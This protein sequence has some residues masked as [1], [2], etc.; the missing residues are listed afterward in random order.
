[1]SAA[2]EGT[3]A[4]NQ[5][6]PTSSEHP[7]QP[8]PLG[9]APHSLL[10]SLL[11]GGSLRDGDDSEGE[12]GGADEEDEEEDGSSSSDGDDEHTPLVRGLSDSK[13]RD[14][15]RE[16]GAN[17]SRPHRMS[18]L[19]MLSVATSDG[20]EGSGIY[21]ITTGP[22]VVMSTPIGASEGVHDATGRGGEAPSDSI[23]NHT[24]ETGGSVDKHESRWAE[25]FALVAGASPG[26][27][28]PQPSRSEALLHGSGS[29][30]QC[31]SDFRG[32]AIRAGAPRVVV[33][34]DPEKERARRHDALLAMQHDSDES[35]GSPAMAC[36]DDDPTPRSEQLDASP[37]L[38][39]T[40]SASAIVRGRSQ[41]HG[42]RGELQFDD[43]RIVEDYNDDDDYASPRGSPGRGSSSGKL[44][45][46]TAGALRSE[47]RQNE[48]PSTDLGPPRHL[49]RSGQRSRSWG[50]LPS[51]GAQGLLREQSGD[52][53]R[54]GRHADRAGMHRDGSSSVG[55][56][57]DATAGE[58]ASAEAGAQ[59]GMATAVPLLV[60]CVAG[61]SR[62][63]TVCTAL[64]MRTR[65][66]TL[67]EAFLVLKTARPGASPNL[68]FFRQL[69]A[70]ELTLLKAGV[71][72]DD[73]VRLARKILPLNPKTIAVRPLGLLPSA[74]SAQSD[75]P[76]GAD[77]S[78]NA[79]PGAAGRK[80]QNSLT[81]REYPELLDAS[82]PPRVTLTKL[83]VWRKRGYGPAGPPGEKPEQTAVASTAAAPAVQPVQFPP[84]PPNHPHVPLRQG[85]T[86]A[87]M[88]SRGPYDWA[89]AS[90]GR[91]A[92]SSDAEAAPKPVP[93]P[94]ASGEYK[95][96]S[97]FL[98][99]AP[100]PAPQS[101]YKAPSLFMAPPKPAE[102]PREPEY[103][104]PTLL[105]GRGGSRS[106]G[107]ESRDADSH[108]S[109]QM[110]QSRQG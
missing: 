69:Q 11:A 42:M 106:G 60:H 52:G 33:L 72:T 104:P 35:S 53:R 1:M 16:G 98:P 84:A 90:T 63:A 94:P 92:T 80:R 29:S 61:L 13:K 54:Q 97:L 99:P 68:G 39:P 81:M 26:A 23:A 65:R 8:K 46:P 91:G 58:D 50:G 45:S 32:K 47:D 55:A 15:G 10:D 87:A 59:E 43:V 56:R 49:Q 107:A 38:P 74:G 34:L 89:A 5:E 93:G 7:Q 110:T 2:T 108:G 48:A 36:P 28:A 95:A 103:R 30:N 86:S 6:S 57:S 40:S 3:S 12:E 66:L 78:P 62:S 27:A 76:S 19:S 14:S 31:Q 22:A 96:P 64:L 20:S 51:V 18:D 105:L 21:H 102:E 79:A 37:Q 24:A 71:L 83:A 70:F 17:E 4:G 25:G 67:R 82:N 77:P 44:S 109:K 75:D 73:D 100:A 85:P 88:P 101:E 9:S 41:T